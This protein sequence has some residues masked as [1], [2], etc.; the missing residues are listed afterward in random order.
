MSGQIIGNC[1]QEVVHS[2]RENCGVIPGP[3]KHLLF[4]PANATYAMDKDALIAAL[5]DLATADPNV[6]RITPVSPVS[7][8][9]PSGGDL[10]TS[11]PGNYGGTGVT[12]INPTTVAYQINNGTPCMFKELSKWNRR[13]LRVFHV[14]D[15][16][17]IF[18]TVR[19]VGGTEKFAGHLVT[20]YAY[21]VQ[22]TGTDQYQLW[23][24]L[25]YSANYENE[26]MNRHG[27]EL[28]AENIPSGL[29]GLR[30][31]ASGSGVKVVTE[32]GGEDVTATYADEWDVSTFVSSTGTT[33]TAA[34]YSA[35]AGT[36]AITPAGSY[37]VADAAALEAAGI[38]GYEGSTQ[39]ATVTSA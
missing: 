22:A 27:F 29:L 36:L 20:A 33:P 11:P 35:G 9:T 25:D 16:A 34:T 1:G 26:K 39:F 23:I 19:S 2:G 14:D 6:D 37:R 15:R 13:T 4:H 31:V 12:G 8:N 18:G 30:L 32:C 5:G 3:T 38:S 10:A 7:G 24:N 28:G 17:M 21:E